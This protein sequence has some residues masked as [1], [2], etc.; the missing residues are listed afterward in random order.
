MNTYTLYDCDGDVCVPD[1]D[2][3]PAEMLVVVE[4]ADEEQPQNAPHYAVSDAGAR[5]EV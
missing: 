3:T 5:V 4:K 2:A 1:I